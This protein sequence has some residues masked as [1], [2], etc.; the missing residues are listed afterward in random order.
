VFIFRTAVQSWKEGK[1][2]KT[3]KASLTFV[4]LWAFKAEIQS[5]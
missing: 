4:L 1:E 5:Q 3:G 2:N